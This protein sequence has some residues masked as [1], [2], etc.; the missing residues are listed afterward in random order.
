MKKRIL[1]LLLIYLGT[2]ETFAETLKTVTYTVTSKTSVVAEGEE[3]VGSVSTFVQTG[4]GQKGQMTAGNSTT[5]TLT[6][7]NG[8]RLH[9]ITLSM[10]SNQSSGSG[11]MHISVGDSV[12]YAIPDLP[13]S[14]WYGNYTNSFVSL[15][16][17]EM[18]DAYTFV[19]VENGGDGTTLE[20]Y[21]EASAN[22]LYVAS[23]TLTYSTEP[24]QA[25]TVQ[26]QTNSAAYVAPITED[27]IGSGILLPVCADADSIWFF[28]GWTIQTIHET[29]KAETLPTIYA[30]GE[31]FYPTSD[32]SLYA[33]YTDT[34]A[35]IPTEWVQDTVFETG[36]YLI[37]D[38]FYQL[39]AMGEVQSDG[40]IMANA[41]DLERKTADS[42]HIYPDNDY[43]VEMVYYIDFLPDSMATIQHVET[44]KYVGF[45][46]SSS[47]SLNKTKAEWN[48]SIT[49][50]KQVIFYHQ[51]KYS[52]NRRE[53]R[54][55]PNN[56]ASAYNW[57]CSLMSSPMYANVLF[58][59]AD[60]PIVDNSVRYTSFPLGS[61]LANLKA[62]DV[63][64]MP[65]GIQNDKHIDILLYSF[66][67]R[68]VTHT[69]HD[70]YYSTLQR[71]YYLMRVAD[72][73]CKIFVP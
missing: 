52:N 21:I 9:N 36:Y 43:A 51:Y 45:P 47:I 7:I 38:A 50:L 4:S 54:A 5:F 64:I 8:L 34:K 41:I 65:W 26:F 11:S 30:A 20:I 67:G 12:L 17:L 44:G 31:R 53:F 63:I 28:K 56:T 3:P 16:L 19:P 70:I 71:G 62:N 6:G 1:L 49:P 29:D 22:S 10:R 61:Y 66:D 32:M 14:S 73:Q 57:A 37:T 24:P 58:D 27:S 40:K 72:R 46:S 60:M 2:L 25:Y 42:L 18:Q 55:M 59:I 68:L 35:I 39:I 15:S 13:F 48:Y 33:L 69:C 23:Y